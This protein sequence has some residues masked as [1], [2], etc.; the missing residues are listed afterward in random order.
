MKEKIRKFEIVLTATMIPFLVI[1][2]ILFTIATQGVPYAG[3]KE[4]K[5][6]E[7]TVE[8]LS[9]TYTRPELLI[10]LATPAEG[11]ASGVKVDLKRWSYEKYTR[12][13]T[14]TTRTGHVLLKLYC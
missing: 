11:T 8:T 12:T 10:E 6:N 14:D 7:E 5:K 3:A 1:V 13:D 9:E 4:L 2:A